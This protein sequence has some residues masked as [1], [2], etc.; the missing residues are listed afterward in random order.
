M[1]QDTEITEDTDVPMPGS[2]P[3]K[4]A[5]VLRYIDLATS[6]KHCETIHVPGNATEM[7]W[8][9]SRRVTE[10]FSTGL[11]CAVQRQALI[12][13]KNY[14]L[15]CYRE[16]VVDQRVAYNDKM[17]DIQ[18]T[19]KEIAKIALH[20][21]SKVERAQER[22]ERIAKTKA[23]KAKLKPKALPK[24]HE[25]KLADA[26]DRRQ[27]AAKLKREQKF[28][29]KL[30]DDALHA[31]VHKEKLRRIIK[32][33]TVEDALAAQRE[34]SRI[35][36]ANKR[37]EIAAQRDPAK[38]RGAP[39]GP[40]IERTPEYLDMVKLRN[41]QHARDTYA[42]KKARLALEKEQERG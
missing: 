24:T 33:A 27:H 18:R 2:F 13:Q 34:R 21:S 36:N 39:L 20:A 12:E 30:V 8:A 17:R 4:F 28:K 9:V 19:Q 6:T 42:R 22:K 26:R 15:R 25:E 11:I 31:A 23:D 29:Q 41:Q 7:A 3:T 14:V 38:R 37:K 10:L 1:E 40:R 32:H 16:R 5:Y 35:W